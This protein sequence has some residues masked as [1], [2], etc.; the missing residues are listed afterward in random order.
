MMKKNLVGML[1]NYIDDLLEAI[2]NTS[3][4]LAVIFIDLDHF[5][6]INAVDGHEMGDR[7]LNV[8]VERI[9]AVLQHNDCVMESGGDDYIVIFR[10]IKTKAE[11]I[12]RTKMLLKK[13]AEPYSMEQKTYHLTASAG[14]S[15]YPEDGMDSISLVR[16]SNIAMYEAKKMG[17]NHFQ[18]AKSSKIKAFEKKIEIE[19][20]L[21]GAHQSD[22]FF[23]VFQPIFNLQDQKIVRLEVLLRMKNADGTICYPDEFLPVAEDYNCMV[24]INKWV[25]RHALLQAKQL[26]AMGLL[27]V[28]I[29]I[30]ISEPALGEMVPYLKRLM[31]NYTIPPDKICIEIIEKNILVKTPKIEKIL[32]ELHEMGIQISI[33]DFGTKYASLRYIKEFNFMIN[34]IKLD[35][36]FIDN[37][38]NDEY[39]ATIILGVLKMASMLRISVTAEGIEREEQLAFLKKIG[40]PEGQGY[41]FSRPLL[42][43]D[44]VLFLKKYRS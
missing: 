23:L 42:M 18:F 17:G 1:I 38:P 26:K 37:L 32:R 13:I 19:H 28:G 16:N 4:K 43:A 30:N 33:D 40:C 6:K 12:T 25:I 35:K 21:H 9:E 31:H 29:A 34:N 11:V 3:D 20:A 10:S 24:P 2:K 15:L 5:R 22:S 44:L 36:L 8:V 7:V 41:Y 14:V 27:T 39:S